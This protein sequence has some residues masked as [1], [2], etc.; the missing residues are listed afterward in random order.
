VAQ[1]VPHTT[2]KQARE[3]IIQRLLDGTLL[4]PIINSPFM[5]LYAY[6]RVTAASA[7]GEASLVSV[8]MGWRIAPRCVR[9]L[10]KCTHSSCVMRVNPM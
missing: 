4:V 6:A 8:N 3:N 7:R 9:T 5:I 1:A 10:I 2:S